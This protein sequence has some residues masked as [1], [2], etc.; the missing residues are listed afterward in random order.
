VFVKVCGLRTAEDVATAVEAG[1]DAVGFVL[2]DSPRRVDAGQ[3][4]ALVATVPAGVLTVAVFRGEPVAEIADTALDCGVA[5]VQLHGEYSAADYAALRQF[6]LRL[7]RAA[8]ATGGD[9]LRC[10][11]LGED[12]LLVDSPTP[13]SGRTWDWGARAVRPEGRW[14]LA[15]GLRP[16]NVAEA[17]SRL[18]PWGVDVSSGVERERGV[19]DPTLIR[20]FVAAA[21]T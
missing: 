17:V 15:G 7:V 6:P 11:D 9:S 16:D 4:A 10:G 8:T 14:L 20:A 19:K 13:G 21:K 3:A 5:A 12:L 18:T 2:T 1:A